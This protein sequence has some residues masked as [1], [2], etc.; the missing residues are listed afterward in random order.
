M[1]V[2]NVDKR[3]SL[4]G[5]VA[6]YDQMDLPAEKSNDVDDDGLSHALAG[7]YRVSESN[8]YG[9]LCWGSER[10]FSGRVVGLRAVAGAAVCG[11]WS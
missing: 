3:E 8:S 1:I 9:W 10:S 5:S 6:A 11:K 2:I 4:D 7:R